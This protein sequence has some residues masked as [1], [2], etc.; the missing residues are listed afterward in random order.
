MT[1]QCVLG[2]HPGAA[3]VIL[4]LTTISAS[5]GLSDERLCRLLYSPGLLHFI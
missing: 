3:Q 2:V 4:L 1:V 5:F